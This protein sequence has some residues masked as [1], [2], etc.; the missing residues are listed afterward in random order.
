[1]G[2]SLNVIVPF[3]SLWAVLRHCALL[4]SSADSSVATLS[5]SSLLSN[6][7]KSGAAEFSKPVKLTGGRGD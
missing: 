6:I 5:P 1:M 3:V 4:L 7:N 2:R